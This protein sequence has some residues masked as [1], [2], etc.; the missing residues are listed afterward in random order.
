MP[1]KAKTPTIL[2]SRG[3]SGGKS[4]DDWIFKKLKFPKATKW[5]LKKIDQRSEDSEAL[6]IIHHLISA[7]YFQY[8]NPIQF[9]DR[10]VAELYHIQQEL[11]IRDWK[12]LETLKGMERNV[13]SELKRIKREIDNG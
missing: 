4:T 1:R 6:Q 8:P 10:M 9:Y 2:V 5:N 7:V 13:R 3:R 12:V 11:E